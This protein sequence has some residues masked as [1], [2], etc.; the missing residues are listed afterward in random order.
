M[1]FLNSNN[2]LVGEYF[3]FTKCLSMDKALYKFI[4]EI[5][6]A[7]NNKLHVG[8]IFCDVA[9]V[10]YCVNQDVLLYKLKFYGI[11]GKA[12]Q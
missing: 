4:D 7:L 5:L 6:H 11:Q 9:K 2:I 12:G 1:Y 3:G 10:I 8:G